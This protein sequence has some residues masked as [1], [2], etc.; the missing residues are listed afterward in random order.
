M[1]RQFSGLVRA[2]LLGAISLAAFAVEAGCWQAKEKA[3][4]ANDEMEGVLTLSFRNA[5]NCEPVARARV[6][7]G[8][9][10]VETDR[11]GLIRFPAPT[12]MDDVAVPMEISAEGYQKTKGYL[13]F[14]F[15]APLQSRYLVSPKLT[16]DRARFIL[17]WADQPRDLDLHLVG[18]GF[19][20]SY[21]N[22]RD[23]PNEARL[24]RDAMDGHGP[25]T[26]TANRIRPD[27]RYELWVH[28]YSASGS[29]GRSAQIQIVLS[30][31]TAQ[32]VLLPATEARWVKIAELDQGE[33]KIIAMPSA[34]G[35]GR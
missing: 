30:D 31:G 7:L 15:N 20:V 28:R 22:M 29:L 26:I 27:A 16:V 25:E 4:W 21:H 35:P 12:G 6:R 5:I 23:V 17:S 8:D 11:L 18:P 34:S 13:A 14:A 9:Q 2:L 24:D 32:A 19:H 1:N 10:E 33:L 3:I